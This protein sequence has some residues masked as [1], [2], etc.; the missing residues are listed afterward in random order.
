[1][2]QGTLTHFTCVQIAALF[3]SLGLPWIQAPGEAEATCAALQKEG[4]VDA[5]AT[6]DSDTLVLG[7]SKVFH[8][9]KL[10]VS[11]DSMT[12]PVNKTSF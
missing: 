10:A 7:A 4:L 12:F 8:T 1:M 9:I 3:S 5:C 11:L 6:K 2:H